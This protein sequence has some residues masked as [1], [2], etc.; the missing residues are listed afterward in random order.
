MRS[1]RAICALAA[2]LVIALAFGGSSDIA[3]YAMPLLVVGSLLL[4]GRFVGEERILALRAAP[5]A[6]PRRAASRRWAPARPA[7]ARSLFARAPRTLR[8]PPACFSI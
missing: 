6:R 7:R 1:P 4:T 3:L 2:A 5:V 8:G